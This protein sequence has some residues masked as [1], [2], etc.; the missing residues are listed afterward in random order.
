MLLPRHIIIY[1]LILFSFTAYPQQAYKGSVYDKR[2]NDPVPFATLKLAGK[3]GGMIANEDG[4]YYLPSNIFLRSDTVIVSSVGY[5]SRKIPL[6][7]LK[8]SADILLQPMVYDL[9]EVN[10]VAKGQ[11]DYMYMMFYDACQKYRKLNEKQGARAYF[12]F[13]SEC[14]NEPLEIIE[15][16]CNAMVSAGGGISQLTIK[17]GR[18][19][20]TLRNFWSLNTTDIITHL[21]PFKSE[22]HYNVPL[23]AG[24]LS[25]HRFKELYLVNF[26]KRSG[27]GNARSYVLRL[28]PKSDSLRLFESMVYINESENTIDRMEF[29]VRNI[30]FWYLRAQIRGDR[31]DSVDLSWTINFDN[32]D[33]VHPRISRMSMDYSLL[34][35]EKLNKKTTRLRTYAEIIFYDYNKPFLNTLGYLGDQSNDYQRIMSVP[36]DSVFWMHPGITPDS[37]KQSEFRDFF[38][39]KGLLL[40][41][42]YGLNSFIRSDYLPWA[43]DRNLEFYELGNA[44]PVSKAIYIPAGRGRTEPRKGSQILGIILINPVEINDSLHFSSVSLVNARSSYLNERQ[45]Y[46][47]TSFINVIFDMYELKRREIINR[48][49]LLEYVSRPPWAT[50]KKLYERELS[51]LQDSI[52]LFYRESWDGTGVGMITK[53]YERISANLGIQRTELIRRM[54]IE[55]QDK[56]KRKKTKI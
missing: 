35:T 43:A 23:S 56:K 4:K 54:I 19:G 29:T 10:L 26:V 49:H 2:T 33:N 38:R 46:R 21:L 5:I 44:P 41:Y 53:W 50:F 1:F 16:Y 12:S 17:N 30:D 6:S 55:D 13:L 9:K 22:G 28:I 25:Y 11:P 32:S 18:I 27:E 3:D 52:R 24:N 14:N 45:S 7:V 42:S 51:N 8:D 39:S 15:A 34:Y 48:F 37:K 40:N 31:V 36:Y 47:A 20:L